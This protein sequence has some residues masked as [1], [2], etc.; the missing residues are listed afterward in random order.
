MQ[1]LKETLSGGLIN[2]TWLATENGKQIVIQKINTNV[3]KGPA[4]VMDNMISITEH[5]HKKLL[6]E[7]RNPDRETLTFLPY[8][9]GKYLETNDEGVFRKSLYIQDS[10]TILKASTPAEMEEAGHLYGDFQRLLSDF[11]A[12]MLHETLPGFHDTKKRYDNFTLSVR[13]DVAERVS[14]C[15][16]EI[17]F[18]MENNR[19]ATHFSDTTLP[20][21]V[22]HNDTKIANLLFDKNTKKALA[23]IDLETV[24]PGLSVFDFGDA[25]RS[26]ASSTVEDDPDIENVHLVKPLYDAYYEG[27]IAGCN[28]ALT[29]EEIGELPYGAAVIIYEQAVRFLTDYIDGDVYYKTSYPDHNLV[30]AKNQIALLNSFIESELSE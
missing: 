19:F 20:L 28:G 3:F 6:A 30:R 10:Y 17:D 11:P 24:M 15:S 29:K 26:G 18:L 8:E 1:E 21:R 27:F 16:E 9:D 7:G 13:K 22:T 23:V 14:S 5:L 12:E 4:A 25:I 2:D